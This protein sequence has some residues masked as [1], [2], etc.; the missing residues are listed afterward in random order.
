MAPEC[1][2]DT[3]FESLKNVLQNLWKHYC[4]I[5]LKTYSMYKDNILDKEYKLFYYFST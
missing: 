2:Y 3:Q 5:N 4:F 1:I